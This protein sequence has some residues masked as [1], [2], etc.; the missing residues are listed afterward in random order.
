MS[1]GFYAAPNAT[2]TGPVP[3]HDPVRWDAPGGRPRDCPGREESRSSL[4]PAELPHGSGVCVTI[5]VRRPRDVEAE[6][7]EETGNMDAAKGVGPEA[8][9]YAAA[10][11][12]AVHEFTTRGGTQKE[13]AVATHVAPATLS[14]YLSGERIAPS[15]Y[16]AALET[17]LAQR[18]RP[19]ATDTQAGW[20]S[21]AD[22]PTRPVVLRPS[23]LPISRKNSLG[24]A[25]RRLP[26]RQS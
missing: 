22:W 23:S 3:G 8:A 5:R 25:R 11:R 17:F 10:L 1:T 20:T 16:V 14:R 9:T 19:M 26:E 21:C 6:E 4:R 12:A 15:G 2:A 24:Y 13:I 18:G 7:R